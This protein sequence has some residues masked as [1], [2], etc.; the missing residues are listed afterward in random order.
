M[1]IFLKKNKLLNQITEKEHK[2]TKPLR[3]T[4]G[5]TNIRFTDRKKSIQ[6]L[7]TEFNREIERLKR[8]FAEK[9]VSLKNSITQQQNSKKRLT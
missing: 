7:R 5:N 2:E 9:K 4:Q 6:D 3:D 1:R 8:T